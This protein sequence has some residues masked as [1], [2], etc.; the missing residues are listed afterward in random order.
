MTDIEE[1]V[2]HHHPTE[3]S[4]HLGCFHFP[5][6]GKNTP[7]HKAEPSAVP[8]KQMGSGGSFQGA[9]TRV[10]IPE[11]EESKPRADLGRGPLVIQ[12]DHQRN[13]SLSC[14]QFQVT[15]ELGLLQTCPGFS[16]D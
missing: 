5:M 6:E 12:E 13:S 10:L 2:L 9:G 7:E 3:R 15:Q 1:L 14:I 8:G 11:V 4:S 16:W